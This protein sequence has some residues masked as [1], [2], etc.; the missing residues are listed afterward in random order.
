MLVEQ[1]TCNEQ[2]AGSRPARGLSFML[3]RKENSMGCLL[4]AEQVQ[5]IKKEID[6]IKKILDG[7]ESDIRLCWCGN[8]IESLQREDLVEAMYHSHLVYLESKLFEHSHEKTMQAL[9]DAKKRT[10]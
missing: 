4:S 8:P 2:V 9:A 7:K 3:R 1:L 5:K 10:I 6:S